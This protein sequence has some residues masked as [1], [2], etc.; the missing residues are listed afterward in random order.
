MSAQ[1]ILCV[2][3]KP[4]NKPIAPISK[5]KKNLPGVIYAWTAPW[6]QG[7]SQDTKYFD[8]GEKGLFPNP[9]HSKR[10]V[11]AIDISSLLLFQKNIFRDNWNG[12]TDI[13]WHTHPHT[14]IH[15]HT[16]TPT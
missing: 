8:G 5:I 11:L 12:M 2:Y 4:Y 1:I 14:Q 3:N 9:K 13:L 10:G 15:T 6:H 16:H 7:V